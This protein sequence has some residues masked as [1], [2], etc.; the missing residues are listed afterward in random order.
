M[1]PSLEDE[2][3]KFYSSSHYFTLLY[4]TNFSCS[5]FAFLSS[6]AYIITFFHHSLG[7]L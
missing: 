4:T 5:D 3:Y 7:D 6:T 2:I 1:G